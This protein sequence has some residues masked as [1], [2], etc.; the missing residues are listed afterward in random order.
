MKENETKWEDCRRGEMDGKG[1]KGISQTH[2]HHHR[3][4]RKTL[5]KKKWQNGWIW[6]NVAFGPIC[7]FYGGSGMPLSFFW[8][9][10]PFRYFQMELCPQIDD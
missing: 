4:G 10:F 9:F 2:H 7:K 3:G 1:K 6:M 5:D 8:G